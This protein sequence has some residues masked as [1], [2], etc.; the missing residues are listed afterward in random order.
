MS[1]EQAMKRSIELALRGTGR[2]SPNPRVGC[3]L[4]KN[5]EIIGEGWHQEYGGVHA[6]VNAIEEA[7]RRLFDVAGSTLIVNLE[8]CSHYGKTPPCA[9]LLI[10]KKIRRVVVGMIDP[11]PE[12]AG[13]GIQK[14]KDAGIEVVMST[15]EAE[16]Q[17]INRFFTKHITTGQPYVMMKIAQSLDGCIAT[18]YGQSKWITSEESR[19]VSH[20]L[21]AE[22]DAVIVGAV[23]ASKDDPELTVRLTEGRNPKRVILD[24][25]LSVSLKAKV[26][27]A[28]DRSN[29]YVFCRP[30]AMSKPK[31]TA[32]KV[33]GVNI[34]PSG[35]GSG[36]YLNLRAILEQL[37]SA[38]VTSVLV[39]GGARLFSSFAQENLVDEL[40]VFT[41]PILIG[42][43]LHALSSLST[44]SLQAAKKFDIHTFKQCGADTYT[45]ATRR[46]V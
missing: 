8:P 22:A 25:D 14:L 7:E 28:E 18:V 24:S 16:C 6:E 26:F 42:S 39:E 12:V 15:M 5:G 20:K 40:H 10:D 41:A 9:D 27:T 33:S 34:I 29:T 45:I 4:V 23:T 37:V 31:A 1:D 38:N 21:R 11:N 19:E 44:P 2:V 32:L 17:W 3:V 46:Q 36:D 30:S 43:G 35:A 13:K